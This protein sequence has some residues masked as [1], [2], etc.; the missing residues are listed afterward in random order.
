MPRRA[1]D[2]TEEQLLRISKPVDPATLP[3]SRD[4]DWIQETHGKCSR[5]DMN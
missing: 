3:S 1:E 2:Y 5:V 4:T